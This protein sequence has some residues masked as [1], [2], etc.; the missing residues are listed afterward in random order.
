MT[1]KNITEFKAYIKTVTTT[2]DNASKLYKTLQKLEKMTAVMM[3]D[4]QVVCFA[5]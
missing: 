3:G 1:F 5:G 4:C 2:A